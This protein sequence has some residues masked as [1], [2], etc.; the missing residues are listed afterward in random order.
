MKNVTLIFPTIVEL[1]DYENQLESDNYSSD[2][3]QLIM[4]G[5]FT[6]RE[7]ELAVNVYFAK[8]LREE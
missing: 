1:T 4:T 6:D 2:R 3:E 7:I 8:V 5:R